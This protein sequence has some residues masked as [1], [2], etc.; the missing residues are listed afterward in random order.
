MYAAD[1]DPDYVRKLE[2]DLMLRDFKET[3][4]R[5]LKEISRYLMHELALVDMNGLPSFLNND[6][7]HLSTILSS[8]VTLI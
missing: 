5:C 3:P 4:Y 6:T 7:E 2:R 8:L 1:K